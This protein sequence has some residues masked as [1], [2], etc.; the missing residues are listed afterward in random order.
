MSLEGA[1]HELDDFLKRRRESGVIDEIEK[2]MKKYEARINVDGSE[3]EVDRLTMSE[4]HFNTV[5]MKTRNRSS[6]RISTYCDSPAPK[7]IN[8]GKDLNLID[9]TPKPTTS[10]SVNKDNYESKLNE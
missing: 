3:E 10:R 2:E 9:K 8:K 7:R 5:G 1:N 6:K 4:E